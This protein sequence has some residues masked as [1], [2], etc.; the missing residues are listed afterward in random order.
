VL[1]ALA[2]LAGVATCLIGGEHG[3]DNHGA[4]FATV[5]AAGLKVLAVPV[6]AGFLLVSFV[7][8]TKGGRFRAALEAAFG[9]GLGLDGLVLATWVGGAAW[10]LV[11]V[12]G[13]FALIRAIRSF[14]PER[15][16]GAAEPHAATPEA[17]PWL[18]RLDDWVSDS[19]PSIFAAFSLWVLLAA[20]FP[21]RELELLSVPVAIALAALV[22]V[23][24]R[25]PAAAAV[26]V[27]AALEHAGLRFEAALVFAVLAPAPGARELARTAREAGRGAALRLVF[28]ITLP[29]L[30]VGALAVAAESILLPLDAP[31]FPELGSRFALILLVVLG[32]RAAFDRGL[33]GLL[34]EVFPSHDTASHDE[35][36]RRGGAAP[37]II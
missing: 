22:A 12:A 25:V 13:A 7:N 17:R 35:P 11:F 37:A 5:A 14:A 23:P 4:A 26:I 28:A 21:Q 29:V 6:L 18:V 2:A 30:A 20:R 34:L 36:S 32:A 31:P 15:S 9:A 33:R 3:A 10:A 8:R 16:L 27:A 24:V 1:D 19:I